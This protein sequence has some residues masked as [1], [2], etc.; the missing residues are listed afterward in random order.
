MAASCLHLAMGS[1]MVKAN[2]IAV[3]L[4]V[5]ETGAQLSVMEDKPVQSLVGEPGKS[6]A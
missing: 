1:S 6:R 2:V 3:P 4:P 5:L